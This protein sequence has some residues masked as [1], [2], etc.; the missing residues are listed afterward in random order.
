M[1]RVQVVEEDRVSKLPANYERRRLQAEW[2]LQENEKRK[3]R[4]ALP[5]HALRAARRLPCRGPS[6]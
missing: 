4:V 6:S 3:A 1:P 2:E 5:R